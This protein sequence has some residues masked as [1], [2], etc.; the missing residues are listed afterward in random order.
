MS[1]KCL[2]YSIFTASNTSY[3]LL[4]IFMQ[5]VA[6]KA[7]IWWNNKGSSVYETWC[8]TQNKAAGL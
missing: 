6:V 5:F 3:V 1:H 4:E 8:T 7:N 2:V